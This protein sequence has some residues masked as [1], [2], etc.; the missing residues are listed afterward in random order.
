LGACEGAFLVEYE[1]ARGDATGQWG[2]ALAG[3][4]EVSSAFCL[5]RVVVSSVARAAGQGLPIFARVALRNVG[6]SPW[7][8]ATSLRIVAGDAY[9]FDCMHIGAIGPGHAA[10]VLLDLMV[11]AE[12]GLEAGCG[13]RSAWVLEDGCGNPFGPLLTFEVVACF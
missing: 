5:G 2:S 6:A 4:P 3:F 1:G 9:G 10:D 12:C 13:R 8:A 7:P 11:M